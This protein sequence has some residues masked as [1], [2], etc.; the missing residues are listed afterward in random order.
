M[1]LHAL[2][3]GESYAVRLDAAESTT[4]VYIAQIALQATNLFWFSIQLAHDLTPSVLLRAQFHRIAVDSKYLVWTSATTLV[5]R[6]LQLA[7]VLTPV[8]KEGLLLNHVK[9]NDSAL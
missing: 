3:R 1:L 9:V 6:R 5:H 8:G 4:G 2:A 7:C